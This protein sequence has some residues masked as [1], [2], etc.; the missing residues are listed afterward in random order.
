[1]VEKPVIIIGGGIWGGLLALRLKEVLPD[2]PFELHEI[3]DELGEGQSISFH[4]SDVSPEA[5]Q[6][7]RPFITG[8]WSR[9]QVEFPRFERNFSDAYCWISQ[10]RFDQRLKT[11]LSPEELFLRSDIRLEEALQRGS[12]VIDTRTHGYFKA[13]GYHKTLALMVDLQRPHG[14]T[15]PITVDARVEQ[16]SG[17]RYLQ[18]L[19]I[20]EDKLYVKDVRYSNHPSLYDDYFEGD[21]LTDLSLR[22]WEVKEVLG[23]ERDFR[24][25]PR[26]E[27]VPENRGRVIRLEGFYHDITGEI[28]PDAIRL[29]E[30]MVGTSFRYGELKEVLKLYQMERTSK[31]K[32]LKNLNQI[33]YQRATPCHGRYA[34]LRLLY[35]LPSEIRKKFYAGEL[36]LMDLGRALMQKP[37]R[38]ASGIWY[39]F[40]AKNEG[41]SS[42][43]LPSRN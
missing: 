23:R 17:F 11:L 4:Q 13:Q 29:I 19:P 31:K 16:K 42:P 35:Q 10:Q 39:Y 27:F 43:A 7:L 30:K 34:Y 15:V 22:G 6:R 26:E 28:L 41:T 36:E 33:L 2:V 21:I 1:M 40:W 20:G 3:S 8:K 37:L 25:I 9:F 38:S 5:F 12:F 32:I 18:Y 24:K 14:M